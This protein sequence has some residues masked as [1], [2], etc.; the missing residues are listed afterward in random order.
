ML[1]QV[2]EH[3]FVSFRSRYIHGS[4]WLTPESF[5][6]FLEDALRESFSRSESLSSSF[7][8]P[9]SIVPFCPSALSAEGRELLWLPAGGADERSAPLACPTVLVALIIPVE[10][11]SRLNPS[12]RTSKKLSF[13]RRELM[14]TLERLSD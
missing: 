9:S 8:P 7:S 2:F 12:N 13:A 10:E 11:G 1:Y 4:L 3:S 6:S 5:A 14:A